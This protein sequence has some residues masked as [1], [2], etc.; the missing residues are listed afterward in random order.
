MAMSTRLKKMLPAGI[1]RPLG[2][3]RSRLRFLLMT[4]NYEALY[5][6]LARRHPPTRSIG[7]GEYEEMGLRMLGVL[8]ME[9]LKPDATV[10]DL[11]CGTGRLAVHAI[12]WLKT[13]GRYIGIDVSKT[14]LAHARTLIGE[15]IPSPLCS[16]EFLHQTTSDF[17][18]PDKTVDMVCAFSV[19]THMEHEDSFRY[20]RSA[21]RIINDDGR[22]IY[23]CLTMDLDIS[24]GDFLQQASLDTVERWAVVRNVTTSRELMDTIARMAGWE[25]IRWYQGDQPNIQLP[26]SSEIKALGQSIC[27]LAPA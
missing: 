24:R 20:L 8:L 6:A 10:V 14:M 1:R 26:Y 17:P 12:P 27:V 7:G 3:I 21:R 22:F 16:I 5:E 25:P 23:S 19:F 18:Q 11:G 4:R 9:G 2:R 13:G 15:K